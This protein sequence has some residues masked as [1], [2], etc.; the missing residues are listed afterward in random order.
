MIRTCV[1]CLS[2]RDKLSLFRVL[3][4]SETRCVFDPSGRLPG[5]GAYVCSL[6][7]LE[8]AVREKRFN[9]AL[10]MRVLQ[11]DSE[12]IIAD[13]KHYIHHGSKGV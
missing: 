5:R 12:K 2:K 13:I 10:R 9:R 1:G 4:I 6:E 11:Q 3:R 8:K 7:C